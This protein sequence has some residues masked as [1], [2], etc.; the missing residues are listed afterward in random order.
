MNDKDK[1]FYAE[2][3]AGMYDESIEL[4][5]PEYE[6]IHKTL[7]DWLDYYLCKLDDKNES[8]I[9]GTII[10]VGAGTGTES[11]SILK[12][13]PNVRILAI[14]LCEPMQKEFEKNYYKVFDKNE[15]KRYEF[16]VED[17]LNPL[18]NKSSL[19]RYLS[20]GENTFLGVIS[21]YCIHHFTTQEKETVYKK[22]MGF[23]E[24]DGF[25]INLDL[26]NYQ[27]SVFSKMSHQ[28]DID[29]IKN[30]FNNPDLKFSK[31]RKIKKEKRIELG[32]KWINHMNT[33]N[34]LEPLEIQQ[35]M[36]YQYEA[37]Q[38][39]LIFRYFQQGLLC[40]IK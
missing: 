29:Y 31:S 24:E 20:P 38:V 10:D 32:N 40:A 3:D 14:D 37:K 22:L 6:L 12:K 33:A 26:F 30:Q 13:F 8:E 7:I 9:S 21:A 11:I 5:V 39:E 15:P 2:Y 23:I 27:S 1:F 28:F 19:S 16:I 35:Q 18:C 34:I 36:L 4:A 17:I 25:L